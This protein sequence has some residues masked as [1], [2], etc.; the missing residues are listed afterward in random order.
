MRK[1]RIAQIGTSQYSHGS[2]IFETI[3]RRSDI[4]EIAGYAL[5][6]NEREKFPEQVKAFEGYREMTVEEILN[7]PDIEAVTVETEEVYLTKYARMVADSKKHIHMEKPGSPSLADFERLIETV[8]RNGTVF[9][10]GYMY[11]YNPFVIELMEKVKSGELGEIIS[12]EAQMSCTHPKEWREWLGNFPGGMLF[13]LGCHLIDLILQIQG[14]PENIIPL[15]RATGL[16]G[17]TGQDL[18]MAVMEYKNGVSFAK[19]CDVEYGGF[20][21]RQVVVVGSKGTVRLCPLE[22][23]ASHGDKVG[24]ELYTD[25]VTYTSLSWLDMGRSERSPEFD[26]YDNMMA[27]FAAMVRGEKQNPYTYDYELKLF[28]TLLKCCGVEE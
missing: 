21:R 14:E 28:K 11:R 15:S 1:I 6:E 19:T 20:S 7:D 3:R 13:F 17:V 18:G 5:P 16:D 23:Y 2:Q 27:S 24:P 9:H 8:K 4:F 12:V 22:M 10:T 25:K 26:R